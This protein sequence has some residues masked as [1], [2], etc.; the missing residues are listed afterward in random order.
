MLSETLQIASCKIDFLGISAIEKWPAT[1]ISDHPKSAGRILYWHQTIVVVC[2]KHIPNTSS[3]RKKCS[4]FAR[5]AF[6]LVSEEKQMSF[7]RPSV[8]SSVRGFSDFCG[9]DMRGGH[10]L[11]SL[12]LL[13]HRFSRVPKK[14][15]SKLAL[16]VSI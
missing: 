3:L 15:G 7:V 11:S 9:R 13:T 10:M 6:P 1:A 12:G 8:R 4:F 14:E 16:R 5:R 2:T